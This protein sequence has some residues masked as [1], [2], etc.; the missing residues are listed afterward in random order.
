MTM[1]P[2]TVAIIDP[3]SPDHL[4]AEFR[5]RNYATVLVNSQ[6]HV[7][8]KL[9]NRHGNGEQ[10]LVEHHDVMLTMT[11]LRKRSVR[12][13]LPD[14]E[15]GVML[16][17]DLSE[18]MALPTN[19]TRLSA[20]RRDKYLMAREVHRAGIAIPAQIASQELQPLLDW[21]QDH[22]TWPCVVKPPNSTGNDGVTVCYSLADVE[23]TFHRLSGQGNV[24]GE[25][26]GAIV[27]Q[28]YVQGV[29]FAV[30]SVSYRGHH[31]ITA[32]WRYHKP[33]GVDPCIGYN[34]M[35]LMPSSGEESARIDSFVKSVLDALEIKFGPAHLEFIIADS[36]RQLV[37]VEIG[38]RMQRADPASMICRICTNDSQLDMTVDAYDAPDRFM[39]RYQQ[40][41]G[42]EQHAVVAFM[43]PRSSGRLDGLNRLGEIRALTSFHEMDIDAG[44]RNPAPQCVGLVVLIHPDLRV[45][46]DD[47]YR[48]RDIEGNGFYQ[49][50]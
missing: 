15:T 32:I 10:S 25:T 18:R 39:Q 34:A 9:S 35:Q 42:L 37:F 49:F 36:T 19:G 20:A 33:T 8:S 46:Q 6:P 27:I 12:F 50:G 4:A 31:R 29:E 16:A 5:K 47:L 26:N 43:N 30:D 41:Y 1:R 11:E 28:E 2:A 48:L 40:S 22:D 13:V 23:Q 45:V 21:A 17:D 24:L 44:P 7:P 3:N 38:A 14:R